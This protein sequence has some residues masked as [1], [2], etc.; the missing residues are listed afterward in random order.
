MRAAVTIAIALLLPA[1]THADEAAPFAGEGLQ[2]PPIEWSTWIRGAYGRG[3]DRPDVLARGVVPSRE[4]SNRW[5]LAAGVEASLSLSPRGNVRLG[6]WLEQR[7]ATFGGLELVLTRVPRR[8]DLFLYEGH[9]IVMLRAGRSSSAD[10]VSLAYGY[11]APFWLEGP[12]RTRF[13]GIETGVC[14]PR[15]E[16]TTRMMAGVRLVGTFTRDESQQWSATVGIE[17]E[18][19]GALRANFGIRSW[20]ER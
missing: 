14:T 20:Y 17:F 10:T 6:A 15:P 5:E 2:R 7:D 18:P 16:R 13:F 11:V 1:R 9:G 4:M 3:T 12:C 8:L 19:L